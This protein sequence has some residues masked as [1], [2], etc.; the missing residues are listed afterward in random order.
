MTVEHEKSADSGLEAL[1]AEARQAPP[2][3]L[4]AAFRTRLIED[5]ARLAQAS[6]IRR[7]GLWSRLFARLADPQRAPGVA[8]VA[9]AGVAG[10]WI[11]LSGPGMTG[12]LITQ[13]WQGVA[14]AAAWSGDETAV[15]TQS[16]SDLLALLGDEES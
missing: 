15:F 14:P 10:L 9:A 16:G 6:R 2:S 11:G 12:E 8:G 5:A 3:P 4:D 7:P 1:F 13:V